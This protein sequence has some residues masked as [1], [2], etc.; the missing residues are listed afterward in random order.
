MNVLFV[1]KKVFKK[2]GQEFPYYEC[3]LDLGYRCV[4]ITK[5]KS[6]IMA[7]AD[8]T[9]KQLYNLKENERFEF[10]KVVSKGEK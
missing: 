7:I 8:I 2:D 3:Y 6:V 10:G 9:D 5:D 1:V 4:C